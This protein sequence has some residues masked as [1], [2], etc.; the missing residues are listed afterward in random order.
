MRLCPFWLEKTIMQTRTPLIAGMAIIILSIVAV[1]SFVRSRV[2]IERWPIG[3]QRVQFQNLEVG[4]AQFTATCGGSPPSDPLDPTGK[5][6]PGAMKLCE[7]LVG[8][9]SLGFH[10]KS[11]FRAD[12]LDPNALTSLY[13]KNPSENNLKARRGPFLQPDFR[14]AH[15]VMDI[16]GKNGT[17]PFN[18]DIS[19][20]CDTYKRKNRSGVTTGMPILYYRANTAG[21]SYSPNDPNS[22]EAIYDVQDNQFVVEL[23]VPWSVSPREHPLA[24][25]PQ[26]FYRRLA[27]PDFRRA[28]WDNSFI[29]LS[30][31][32]DGLYGTADDEYYFSTR[33]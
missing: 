1:V 30:A 23:G 8:R 16:Y 6:Y 24:S 19:V 7:A 32:K 10:A 4:I 20:L 26:A 17:D 2:M 31:G 14:T 28:L 9:D 3:E 27:D 21:A 29:L 12:A 5:P 11:I 22:L 33:Q 18:G 15:K 25:D 13:P